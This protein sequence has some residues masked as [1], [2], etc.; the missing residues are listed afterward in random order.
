[1]R[2]KTER[3]LRLIWVFAGRKAKSLISPIQI[4]LICIFNLHLTE[5]EV[6]HVKLV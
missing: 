2:T 1:M 3:I 5:G 6:V 4:Q